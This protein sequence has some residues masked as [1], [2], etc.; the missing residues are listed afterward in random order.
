MEETQNETQ[1]EAK[2]SSFGIYQI[3]IVLVILYICFLLYQ[4]LYSNYRTSQTIKSLKQDVAALE[5]QRGELEVLTAYYKTDSF[6][7]LEA[8]K[9]L[10]LRMPGEK[11]IK[12]EEVK[13]AATPVA[14]QQKQVDSLGLQRSNWEQWLDFVKGVDNS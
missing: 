12:V 6:Q 5:K 2:K 4:S 14:S 8:R 11:V 3:L 7:E 1:K 13:E 10:G 9:K